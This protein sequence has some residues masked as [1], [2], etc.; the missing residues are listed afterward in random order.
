MFKPSN[1]QI[2]RAQKIVGE[3]LPLPI[4]YRIAIWPLAS[5]TGLK[6]GEA[7]QYEHLAKAGFQAQSNKQTERESRGTH[8]G[9]LCHVGKGG[10]QGDYKCEEDV[11][12]E[13]DIV[14]FNKYAGLMQD[15]PPGSEGIYHFCN[16]EDI[17]GKYYGYNIVGEDNG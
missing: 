9:V 2:N 16:D 8:I 10:F 14:V 7:Q 4:G 15:F 11:P 5:T 13:G 1:E 3:N 6:A 17:Q 12:V